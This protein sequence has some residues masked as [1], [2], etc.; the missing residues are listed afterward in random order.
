VLAQ[1][2]KVALRQGRHDRTERIGSADDVGDV[3]AANCPAGPRPG[4]YAICAKV[5]ARGGRGSP[6]HRP[7]RPEDGPVCP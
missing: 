4:W 2:G 5:E 7:A 1:T 3:D 6:G